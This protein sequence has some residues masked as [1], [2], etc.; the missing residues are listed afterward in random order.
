[1][2]GIKLSETCPNWLRQKDSE[3]YQSYLTRLHDAK[4]E[5]QC[6]ECK[7]RRSVFIR[8]CPKC[9]SILHRHLFP[10]DE[11]KVLTKQS[12]GPAVALPDAE[13]P[14]SGELLVAGNPVLSDKLPEY[15]NAPSLPEKTRATR[16]RKQ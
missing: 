11:P 9:N 16:N 8:N 13:L 2:T 5:T 14:D 15:Q 3:P 6:H 1:M 10:V 7:H 12:V 4:C